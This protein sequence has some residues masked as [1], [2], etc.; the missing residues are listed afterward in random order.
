MQLSHGNC[1]NG[2]IG[3]TKIF[4]TVDHDILCN[5]LEAM[6]MDFTD[7]FKSYLGGRQQVVIANDVSSDPMTVKCGVQC[8]TSEWLVMQVHNEGIAKVTIFKQ[9]I[10][11][12]TYLISVFGG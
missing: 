4:D 7:W 6:V 10:S 2:F 9:L 3:L 12:T 5:K 11:I 1:S 8:I